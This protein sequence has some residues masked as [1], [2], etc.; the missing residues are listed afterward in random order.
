MLLVCILFRYWRLRISSASSSTGDW[1]TRP[2]DTGKV[3][4]CYWTVWFGFGSAGS[5]SWRDSVFFNTSSKSKLSFL[6]NLIG[7][8]EGKFD[9]EGNFTHRSWEWK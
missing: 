8:F 3:I 9:S 1:T 2:L 6:N 4:L 7:P 5:S